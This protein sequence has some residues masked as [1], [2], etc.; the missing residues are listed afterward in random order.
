MTAVQGGQMMLDVRPSRAEIE[1]V[2]LDVIRRRGAEVLSTARRHAASVED[3]E[4][5]YQRALEILLTKAPSTDEDVLVPW[6]KVVVKH[7]AYALRRAQAR[8]VPAQHSKLDSLPGDLGDAEE[9]AE[10][11]D[12]LRVGAEALQRL[13]P[14]ETRC[15]VLLAEG[16]TYQQIQ[17]ATGFSYTKVNRCLSEGRRAF[18]DRVRGI[19]SGE[20]CERMAPLLSLLA[21]GEATAA[22][23]TALRPHLRG[24]PACRATLR[25]YRAAPREL[26][27]VLGPLGAL[28]GAGH[29]AG[30]SL[31]AWFTT[32]AVKFRSVFELAGAQKI[33]VV[34]ASTVAIAG[35]GAAA[36]HAMSEPPPARAQVAARP[37][38]QAHHAPVVVATAASPKQAPT[39]AKQPKHR[40]VRHTASAAAPAQAA[41]TAITPAA[42]PRTTTSH[43]AAPAKSRPKPDPPADPGG[44]FG[45]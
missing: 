22:D 13:K 7:E 11:L 9:S 20:E 6:L 21:D 16:Y 28:A 30:G 43:A 45:P 41:A 38:P 37:H 33:A 31:G 25:D 26:A 15:M 5:A 27:A 35:G 42:A 12:R 1:T 8:D 36:M 14:Q 40:R 17:E 19:E 10:R 4:D 3:A 44:E 32:V 23:M 18:F 29:V 39:K 24:C 2:A 34:A